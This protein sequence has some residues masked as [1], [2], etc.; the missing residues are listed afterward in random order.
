MLPASKTLRLVLAALVVMIVGGFAIT[1]IQLTDTALSIQQRLS[2]LP[3]WIAWPLGVL[4]LACA[5]SVVYLV[6]KL[7][8][9]VPVAKPKPRVLDVDAV[10]ERAAQ[11]ERSG[12]GATTRGESPLVQSVH[13]ELDQLAQRKATEAAYVALF[14][15]IS[16]GKSSLIRALCGADVEVDVRGGTT[17]QV[18]TFASEID[19]QAL[20]ISDVP[21]TNEANAAERAVMAR[22][23]ALRAH[24]VALV[25]TGDLSRSQAAEWEWLKAFG[26]PMWLILNKI[27]R[28][29]ADELAALKQRLL[30][31]FGAA[32]IAVHAAFERMTDIEHVDGRIEQ[33][34]RTVPAQI[35]P[36]NARLREF[37][38]EF[39][40]GRDDFEHK[41]SQSVLMA[42]DLKLS[43]AEFAQRRTRA[44][45]LVSSYQRKAIIGA[46]ASVAPGTDLLVQGAL[47]VGLIKNLTDLYGVS[48]KDVDIDDLLKWLGGRFKA[49]STALLAVAG[50]AAK[51]FPGLGT[52]GGG[53]MHAIAYGLIFESV[54]DALT[55]CLEQQSRAGRTSGL[56]RQQLLQGFQRALGDHRALISRAG[57]LAKAMMAGEFR[58]QKDE[59]QS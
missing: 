41:R 8:K 20:M 35:E 25:V 45:Q 44:N 54:G 22:E 33:R 21:G 42:L 49:S 58:A 9:P 53:V 40:R 4:L 28:Y 19:G 36:L 39:H 38:R 56:D 57:V 27:D 48:M 14:G 59:Q 47:A 1:L 31:K 29:H 43:E 12:D 13:A 3:A 18:R 11:L 51:A 24:C 46:M 6:W 2:L 50:N 10:A 52:L 30:E 15:E 16:A 23:E 32:P 34:M 7:L 37:L 5:F 26:K 55:D 17:V